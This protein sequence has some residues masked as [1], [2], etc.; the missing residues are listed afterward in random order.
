MPHQ[1]YSRM[2]PCRM[3]SVTASVRVP[4]FNLARIWA[5]WNLTVCSLMPSFHAMVLFAAP[6]AN[7]RSTSSSRAVSGVAGSA[8][9]CG[10]PSAMSDSRSRGSMAAIPAAAA[11]MAA[12]ISAAE[13]SGGSTARTPNRG[14]W[15]SVLEQQEPQIHRTYHDTQRR[16]RAAPQ[17]IEHRVGRNRDAEAV[18]DGGVDADTAAFGIGL[19]DARH[20]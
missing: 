9:G 2:S 19:Q 20:P 5:T 8:A 1:G 7:M 16:G 12:R 10:A 15:G 6:S 11:W 14:A 17:E 13:A 18:D 3:P 4:A